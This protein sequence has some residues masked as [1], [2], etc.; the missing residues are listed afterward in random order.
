MATTVIITDTLLCLHFI[1]RY[2]QQALPLE[3]LA[4]APPYVLARLDTMRSSLIGKSSSGALALDAK[5]VVDTGGRSE[6]TIE[7][8]R[9][10]VHKLF[11][12]I[13][14]KNNDTNP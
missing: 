3:T 12:R 14:T 5:T 8:P 13:W 2:V 10:S 4:R 9:S 1:Q 11:I 6:I 7:S